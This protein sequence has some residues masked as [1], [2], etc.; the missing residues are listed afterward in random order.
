MKILIVDDDPDVVEAITLSFGLQWPEASVVSAQDG[1]QATS[2]FARE[3]PDVVLLDISLPDMD[4]FEILRRIRERSDV[5]VLMISA[6]GEEIDKVRGLELGAD[7][8]VTKPFG[9]LELSARIKAVVRRAHSLPP[10]S[11]GGKFESGALAINYATHQVFVNDKAVKL[12]PIEYKLLYQLTRNAGQVL[13]HDHLLTKIWGPE[14]LGELDYLRIYVRRLREKLEVQ[15]PAAGTDTHRARSRLPLQPRSRRCCLIM[16]SALPLEPVLRVAL[17]TTYAGVNTTGVGLYSARLASELRMQA[18]DLALEIRCFGSACKPAGARSNAVA[19]FQ[20]WPT[21]THGILPLQLLAAGPQ[22]VHSTSHIGPLRGPGKL[23]VTV[24]DLIFMR[25]PQDYQRGWLAITRAL[26]PFVLR[27]AKAIIA[28]SHATKRDIQM[29]FGVSERKIAVIYPGIDPP[30]DLT[31][32]AP[33]LMK[34]QTTYRR[35]TFPTSSVLARGC[36]A[37]TSKSS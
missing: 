13:L 7:D 15:P 6:R 19:T 16:S 21:Y 1:R 4:G 37:R 25:Y 28:D 10:M 34:A 27:R 17:D 31:E 30:P 20:E 12:T 11:G 32:N 35:P 22:I 29:F 18:R 23:I 9:Y 14:Y 24:H 3:N 26:L 33:P 8:Y 5:P 36:A 2:A